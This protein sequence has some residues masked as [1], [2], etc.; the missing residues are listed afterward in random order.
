M[1]GP[2]PMRK[3][4]ISAISFLNTAP[5]MWNFEQGCPPS[6]EESGPRTY[7]STAATRQS[8]Q[9]AAYSLR[10]DFDV[11][12]TT[13][14]QCAEELHAGTADIGIIP[15]AA[16]ASTSDLV[17]VPDVAIAA[18]GPVRS[19]L[20]VSKVPL[21]RIRTLA[22]DNSSRTSVALGRV[23]FHH[24]FKR[25]PSFEPAE[26]KLESMLARCDSALLIGD[27][28]LRVDR[29]RYL[30]WDLAE[31]WIQ[32]TGKPF[33]FAFWAVRLA[34]LREARPGLD[35]SAIFQKSRDRGLRPESIAAIAQVWSPRVGLSP[36]AICEY[37][38]QNVHY[39]LD[40]QCIAGM[41]LFFRYAV[42]CGA[43]PSTP[44]RR[45]LGTLRSALAEI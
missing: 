1:S 28:A 2:E 40:E 11:S 13:P 27:P 3:F 26:P 34:A 31:E 35:V 25:V 41:D 36:T 20:L 44:P 21:E 24:W 14:S 37:L 38:T 12:Y 7:Q 17:I 33:V 30:T 15:V 39:W 19:I 10:A 32:L 16:Y 45:F 9:S 22:A 5:L 42:E 8:E 18:K 29:S 4:R 23:L 6:T 43:L